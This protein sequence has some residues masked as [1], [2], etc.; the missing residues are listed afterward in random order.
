MPAFANA[1]S[2]RPYSV[3]SLVDRAFEGRVIRHVGDGATHV[4]PLTLQPGD[5]RG[6]R[7]GVDID[8]R[9]QRAVCREH[10]AVGEPE[11]ARAA[12]DDC[13]EAGYVETRGNVHAE[14]PSCDL[15]GG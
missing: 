7:L 6:D 3:R 13:A 4:E 14:V 5:L 11:P 1:T 10:L 15:V 12:G 9:D 2:S 8:E